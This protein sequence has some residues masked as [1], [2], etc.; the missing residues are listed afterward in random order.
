MAW[1]RDMHVRSTSAPQQGP[2]VLGAS[3]PSH[4]PAELPV[5]AQ[6]NIRDVYY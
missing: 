2:Y 1:D 6:E 4:T 5:A 3:V